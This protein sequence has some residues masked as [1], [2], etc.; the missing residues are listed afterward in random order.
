MEV[1]VSY[2]Y[3][4]LNLSSLHNETTDQTSKSMHKR[5]VITAATSK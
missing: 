3:N 5:I 1:L 4:Y 2:F